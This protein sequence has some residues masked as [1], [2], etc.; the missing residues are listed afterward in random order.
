[1]AVAGF[2]AVL[3][4]AGF[5]CAGDLLLCRRSRG[6]FSINESF[7]VGAT[8]VTAI[9]F[10]V[11]LIAGPLLIDIVLVLLILVVAGWLVRYKRALLLSRRRSTSVMSGKLSRL[12]TRFVRSPIHY[13]LLLLL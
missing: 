12:Q 6:I 5:I 7:L 10:P 9:L 4:A 2:A 1:M 11:S 13:M 3:I 8:A